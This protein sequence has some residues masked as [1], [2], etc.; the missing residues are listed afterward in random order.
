MIIFLTLISFF[1]NIEYIR[2]FDIFMAYNANNIYTPIL[3]IEKGIMYIVA[4]N[5]PLKRY[6]NTNEPIEKP[7]TNIF[8]KKKN[9]TI[10]KPIIEIPNNQ[11]KTT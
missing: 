3:I 6:V 4:H 5:K 2:L 10:G 8:E 9:K 7:S 11:M 1:L